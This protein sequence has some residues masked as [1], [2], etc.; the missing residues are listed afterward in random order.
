M[1][2]QLTFEPEIQ[3]ADP[4]VTRRKPPAVRKDPKP[5]Y[6]DAVWHSFTTGEWLSVSH[7][8]ADPAD[9]YAEVKRKLNKAARWCERHHDAEVRVEVP[10]AGVL[11]ETEPGHEDHVI[12]RFR[13]HPPKML[14]RRLTRARQESGQD[15]P[16]S[17]RR[18]VVVDEG[19]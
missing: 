13:G 12:I 14:G 11:R 17:R 19:A 1:E 10:P 15:E 5:Q 18:R 6:A 16:Q 4:P 8:P 9:G 7:Q 2:D 3:P